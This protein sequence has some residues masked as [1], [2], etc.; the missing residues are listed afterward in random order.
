MK[1][2]LNEPG[3]LA[4]WTGRS[5][6]GMAGLVVVF[7]VL[8]PTGASAAALSMQEFLALEPK[9]EEL[10]KSGERLRIEGRIE[11]A[12]PNLVRL[13]HCPIDFRPS[14]KVL[15]AVNLRAIAVEITGRLDWR[16]TKLVF[17]VSEM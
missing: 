8:L 4:D 3:R 16:N 1:R 5:A 9:W 12:S 10:A 17:V 13:R 7:A 14:G 6:S 11:S 2:S 15:P